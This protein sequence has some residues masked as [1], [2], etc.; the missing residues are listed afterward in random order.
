MSR[1]HTIARG[2]EHFR[3]DRTLLPVLEIEP[4]DTVAYDLEEVSGGQITPHS[5]AA[6]LARMNMDRVYPLAG[7]IYAKGARPDDALA[8]TVVTLVSGPW[9]WTSI[10]P[11]LGLL[12]S[13]FEPYLHHWDLT[14][15]DHAMLK[16]GVRV[17]LEP[18]CGTMGVA[19]ADDGQL[20]VMPPGPFGGNMDIR[21]LT[22][23]STVILPVWTDGALFSVGDCHAAQGDGEVSVSAIECPMRAVLRFDVRRGVRLTAPRF[24]TPGPLAPRAAH[25][26]YYATTGIGPDLMEGARAAIRDMIRMLMEEHGLTRE[27]AYVLCSV[28]VDLK[29]SEVVDHPNW[30]VSAYLPRAVLVP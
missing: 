17:P 9:G 27:E 3:W 1:E 8:V 29:L 14:A 22:V 28:A 7:P 15:G 13:E 19:P 4:G 20:P 10:S 11:D 2:R 30:V 18:F 12:G 23:G 21:H 16:P 6:D 5:T 24:M 26:G 25:R